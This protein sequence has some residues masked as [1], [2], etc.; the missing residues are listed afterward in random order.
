MIGAPR[1]NVVTILR[2]TITVVYLIKISP[3]PS[4]L[5]KLTM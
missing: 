2:E 4:R 3:N 5:K 1:Q